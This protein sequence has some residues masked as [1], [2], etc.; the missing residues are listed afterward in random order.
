M[1]VFLLTSRVEGLPNVLIE[2]Q[3]LGVPVVTTLVGGVVETFENGVTGFAV[4]EATGSALAAAILRVL[5]DPQFT[6][7]TRKVAPAMARDRFSVDRM[8]QETLRAYGLHWSTAAGE[9][10]VRPL[11]SEG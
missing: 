7:R 8:V 9:H 2:A 1:D 5:R 4:H 6:A 10:A 11:V 3:A